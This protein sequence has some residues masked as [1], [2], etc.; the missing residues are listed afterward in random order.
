MTTKSL[1]DSL[2]R[3]GECFYPARIRVVE[4]AKRLGASDRVD[5]VAE[6]AWNKSTFAFAVQTRVQFNPK[7][8]Q[9]AAQQATRL[10]K[11]LKANPMIVT[12]FLS[13]EQLRFL[14]SQQVSGIDLCG[15]GVILVP[16]RLLIYRTGN[17]NKYP[18]SSPIRNVYR[19]ASSLVA[20]TFLLRAEYETSQKLLDE[21]RTRRGDVTLSTISKACSSLEDD[22]IIERQRKGRTT[23]LRLL[24]AEKL[25]NSLADNYEAPVIRQKFIGKCD[26]DD[27]AFEAIA[28]DWSQETQERVVRTGSSSSEHYATMAREPIRCYYC[29]D[30]TG[31][32]KR[33]GNSARETER[34]PN[35]QVLETDDPI[36]FFDVRDS[37]DASPL[38]AFLE[39]NAGDKRERETAE[40]IRQRLLK[41]VGIPK[42]SP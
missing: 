41:D 26:L 4:T 31:I 10:A 17:P 36:V 21:I 2:R 3:M 1:Q 40:Q 38:Q 39:L 30:A 9:E 37:V 20:R 28:R 19:G 25:L 34:F 24:Q 33:L 6:V 27:Q 15:N 18:S 23:R 42:R 32:L 7:A 16:N 12:P 29:T 22:L 5:A 14:E 13:E 35:F 11:Q 8:I